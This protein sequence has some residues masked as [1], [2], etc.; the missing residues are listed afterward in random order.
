MTAT[1]TATTAVAPSVSTRRPAVLTFAGLARHE[2]RRYVVNPVFLLGASLTILVSATA[3]S[4]VLVDINEM[5]PLTAILLGGFAMTAAF[6]QARSLRPS[7][8]VIDTTPVS[9]P[10][11]SA[12]L[13]TT[14]IVPLLCGIA[15]LLL[16]RHNVHVAGD[17]VYGAF[18][19]STR[20][21]GQVSQFV[22]PS[23]GGPLLGVALGRWVRFPGAGF[24]LLVLLYAWV[25]VTVLPSVFGPADQTWTVGLRF[26]GPY[27]FWAFYDPD[28]GVVTT[29]RG[30]PWFFIGWQL[31][32]CAFA[33]LVA[34]LRGAEG[35]ARRRIVRAL[36]GVVVIA[37]FLLVLAVQGGLPHVVTAP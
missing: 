33:V 35:A 2:L 31:A 25:S 4:K 16:F 23:L 8:P 34:L 37:A 11:R 21:A 5:T 3:G 32:L 24:V 36:G 22:V 30:S 28:A 15:S 6:W 1:T 7:S 9:L 14:A 12:A 26:L 17:W 20:T 13:C 29:L 18:D 27:A 10:V 19:P